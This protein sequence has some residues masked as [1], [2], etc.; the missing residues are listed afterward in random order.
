MAPPLKLNQGR[1]S[2]EGSL[3]RGGRGGTERIEKGKTLTL[4]HESPQ[5]HSAG[6]SQQVHIKNF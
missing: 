1:V 4:E 5:L 3:G 6:S 2:N